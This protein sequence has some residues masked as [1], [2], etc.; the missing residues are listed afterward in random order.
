MAFPLIEMIWREDLAAII[1][2]TPMLYDATPTFFVQE[3]IEVQ[4]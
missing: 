3:D 4:E 2:D 1:T